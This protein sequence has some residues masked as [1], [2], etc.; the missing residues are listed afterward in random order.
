[1]SLERKR[2]G[3]HRRGTVYT[4][5]KRQQSNEETGLKSRQKWKYI[6]LYWKYQQE[7]AKFKA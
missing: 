6:H 5:D 7:N 2:T 1:M 3:K 4:P